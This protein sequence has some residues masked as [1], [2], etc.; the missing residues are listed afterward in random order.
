MITFTEQPNKTIENLFNN[1]V[2]EFN[3]ANGINCEVIISNGT[4]VRKLVIDG[5]N[6]NFYLDAK[7]PVQSLFNVDNFRDDKL[8]TLITWLI[9]DSDLYREYTFDFNVLLKNGTIE[10]GQKLIKYLKSVEQLTEPL[11]VENITFKVLARA[12][13]FNYFEGL[14]MD[15]SFYCNET[16]IVTILNK[17]TGISTTKQFTKG[18]N[19]L[20]LSNGENINGFESQV[21]L[22][23]DSINQ[24]EFYDGLTLLE[25]IQVYK[26]KECQAP[27]LK[28]FNEKGSWSYFRFSKIYQIN[29]SHKNID[30]I[31]ND[32]ANLQKSKGNFKTLGKEASSVMIIKAENLQPFEQDNFLSIFTSPK[33]FLYNTLPN[34]PMTDYSFKEVSISNGSEQ[35]INTK[36]E[37]RSFNVNVELPNLY[38]QTS[39]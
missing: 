39:I 5:I 19:R 15:I 3:V 29:T 16:K 8:P 31:N 28:W 20:Y 36:N 33:V 14:P 35:I 32:F 18:V 2:F 12:K 11:N 22:I 21:P 4:N 26:H 1:Q 34:Q 9:N 37:I 10:S 30:F 6:G 25:T 23:I 17:K 24:L 38:T 13:Y 7:K 27:Y